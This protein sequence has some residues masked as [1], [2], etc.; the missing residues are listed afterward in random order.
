MNGDYTM[1][2]WKD[3]TDF[4]I[5]TLAGSYGL[6]DL[7]EFNGDLTLANRDQLESLIAE[8]EIDM[9]FGE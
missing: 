5:A 4:E 6:Q 8:F 7:I 9:A 1:E 2:M 3:F